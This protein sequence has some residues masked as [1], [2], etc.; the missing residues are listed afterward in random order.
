MSKFLDE[1]NTQGFSISVHSMK[2]M[3]AAVGAVKLS[4]TALGLETASKERELDYC[5]KAFPDFQERL[6][7]LHERLSEIFPSED[8]GVS[9]K[10]TGNMGHLR[11]SVQKAIAAADDFDS[12]AGFETICRLLD[13][14]FGERSNTLLEN[15]AQAFKEFDCVSAAASLKDILPPA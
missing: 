11:E 6:L 14:D 10:K 13:Y 7:S 12:D 3:L 4:E 15:A 5:L 2:S 9:E 8:N 1:K